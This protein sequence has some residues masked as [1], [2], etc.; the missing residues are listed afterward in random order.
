MI[1]MIRKLL[2]LLTLRE[3]RQGAGVLMMIII[4]ALLESISVAAVMPFLGVLGNPQLV[5]TEPLLARSYEALGFGSVDGFLMALGIAVFL[6]IMLSSAFRI[7]THY[8]INR[9]LEMRRHSISERLLANF[10]RQ[11]YAYFLNRHSADMA[12]GVLS[13]VD[14]LVIGVLR[15]ALS[16]TAYSVVALA[17]IGL[18]LLHD[19]AMAL[20]IAAILGGTYG[21]IYLA[22][23]GLLG[24]LGANQVE[25][26]SERFTTANEA[27]GGIK[28]IKLLG[29][30]DAYLSRFRP[31]SLRYSRN[32]VSIQTASELPRFSVEATALG[33]VI[34]LTLVLM[35][36]HG[37]LGA[38]LPTLGLYAFAGF[39]L[40]PA[41]QRVYVGLTSLRFGTAA[42]DNVHADLMLPGER[43]HDRS[44]DGHSLQ[45]RSE[46][47][48]REVSFNYGQGI[49]A[50]LQ[51]INLSLPVGQSIA[52]VGGTGAGKTTLVDI[53]LGL[54]RPTSGELLL[55]GEV[56]DA[57]NLRAWQ[58]TLGYVPQQ[59]FLSDASVS[60][61][62]ALGIAADAIDPEQVERCA[63]M[64]QIHDFVVDRMPQGYA[65][66]VGEE[67]VRLS[68][69]QR[70]RIGIARAL[71]H[72]PSVLV[73]DEATSAL[74]GVTERAVMASIEALHGQR[75]II[76]IA[77]RL[78][79]V[80]HCD[81]IHLL[82]QGRIVASG[83]YAELL[84]QES[85]FRALAEYA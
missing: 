55:D 58:R 42:L 68:G 45:P 5:T 29:R 73:F 25:V 69:G 76:L 21:F 17:L 51:N 22:V 80:R 71:Y 23:R 16:A 77:H 27:L 26:N 75:T 12:K 7:A 63:R 30:E 47:R 20:A 40:I 32:L 64:A 65:T 82:D 44:R 53:L 49:H 41:L 11:P 62:I 67:G 6:V 66:R 79:T 56:I 78:A 50:A 59:I 8:M 46:I 34:A 72:E 4:M 19:P 13:E 83:N 39:K 35:A 52:L 10:L 57:G 36:N 31:A 2:A 18:L 74:D 37:D 38:M 61:N 15:P 14:Y 33:G 1:V 70:Q 9:Y 81:Q 24:R 28:D 3:R 85:R 43:Q 54:L 60:E 48:L 84:A